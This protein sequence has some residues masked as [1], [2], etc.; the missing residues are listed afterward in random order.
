MVSKRFTKKQQMQ[1]SH[2]GAHLLLQTRSCV[3]NG[4]LSSRFRKWYPDLRIVEAE[5]K[6]AA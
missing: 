2:R 6:T 5:L 1:W 4:E 3:L